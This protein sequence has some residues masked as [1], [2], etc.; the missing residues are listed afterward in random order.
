MHGLVVFTLAIMF[1][2]GI[3]RGIS[4]SLTLIVQIYRTC[5]CGAF[6]LGF[7]YFGMKF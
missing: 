7:I 3:L 1:S 2:V 6:G 4:P 5:L